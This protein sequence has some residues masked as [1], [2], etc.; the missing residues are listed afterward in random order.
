M[1]QIKWTE[2]ALDDLNEIAEY[3]ALDKPSAAKKLV[4]DT[5]KSVKRLKDFPNSG[6]IP[7]EL[8]NPR[9][10]E[11]VVGPCRVF[12][13]V[14]VDLVFI[15]YVMRSERALRNFILEDRNA[16]NS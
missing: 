9:Y 15:L 11:I 2:P 3:I 14:E 4:K 16:K 7:S 1:A 10:R 13:R 6:K 8:D 12:Y 5:F